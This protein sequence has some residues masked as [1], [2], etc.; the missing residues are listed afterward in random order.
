MKYN[1]SNITI[2]IAEDDVCNQFF[3]KAISKPTNAKIIIAEDGQQAIE[4]LENNPD[5]QIALIDIK[6]P[7]LDGLKAARIIKNKFKNLPLIAQTAYSDQSQRNTALE[8]GFDQFITKPIK[9]DELFN[10]IRSYQFKLR[11]SRY[12][13]ISY[14]SD[15]T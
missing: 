11:H 13:T 8:A 7:V 14:L 4:Y 6:M 1:F 10:I 3:F 5:I 15:L 2:L 12:N 9:Q